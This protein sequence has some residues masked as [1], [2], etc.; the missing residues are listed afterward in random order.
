MSS[1]PRTGPTRIDAIAKNDT[2]L[3]HYDIVNEDMQQWIDHERDEA[4]FAIIGTVTTIDKTAQ[5]V[6][7]LSGQA[8]DPVIV[9]VGV[10]RVFDAE[11]QNRFG[12][13]ISIDRFEPTAKRR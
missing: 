1:E 11:T 9:D 4:P 13:L 12:D 10:E 8:P 5:T 6:G 7:I 3:V 2:V